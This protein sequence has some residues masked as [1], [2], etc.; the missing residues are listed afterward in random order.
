MLLCQLLECR[1]NSSCSQG[2][3]RV[4]LK[5]KYLLPFSRKCE[6]SYILAKFRF[7]EN[8]CNFCKPSIFLSCRAHLLLS[9]FAKILVF[10]KNKYSREISTKMCK[11]SCHQKYYFVPHDA[12]NLVFLSSFSNIF[13]KMRE[14]NFVSTLGTSYTRSAWP[15]PASNMAF[16]SLSFQTAWKVILDE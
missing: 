1:D 15:K 8:N 13:A 9:S 5:R 6:L 2:G 4:G 14:K 7:R 16:A 10:A 11:I 3:A 12:D